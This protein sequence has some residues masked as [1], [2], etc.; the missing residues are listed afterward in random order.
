MLPKSILDLQDDLIRTCEL[1]AEELAAEDSRLNS[2]G[3]I[4]TDRTTA[5]S[6]TQ[7]HSLQ[8]TND[9]QDTPPTLSGTVD[10]P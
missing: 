2:E 6:Q 3:N 10:F 7:I 5:A 4:D 8:N 9:Y 1:E